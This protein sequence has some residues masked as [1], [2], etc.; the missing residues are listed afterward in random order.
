MRQKK[1]IF[2]I[3]L[4]CLLMLMVLAGLYLI[5]DS[6][7]VPESAKQYTDLQ[8]RVDL[9]VKTEDIR[10]WQDAVGMYYFFLPSTGDLSSIAFVNIADED[11]LTIN[12]ASSKKGYL[13]EAFGEEPL[14]LE[15]V[16]DMQLTLEGGQALE[17][18]QVQF[19]KS[20]NLATMFID[21]ESG[22]LD[23]IHSSKEIEEKA[24]VILVDA[25]GEINYNNDIQYIRTRGNS[26]FHYYDKKAYQ[27]KLYNNASLLDMTKSEKWILLANAV[28][29]SLIRNALIYDFADEYTNIPSIEGRFIDLYVN[30]T[31][32]GN[33]YL[34]EKIEVDD[35]RLNIT[36]LEAYNIAENGAVKVNGATSFQTEDGK[37]RACSGIKNPKDITGG[38][39]LER[40]PEAEYA[41]VLSG[42][43]TN[44]GH[45]FEIVSPKYATIEQA[46]YIC[47]LFNE[48]EVAI[49]ADDGINPHTGKHYT[50]YIDLDSWIEKYLIDEL[51]HN[52]DAVV[53]SLFFYKDS[54]H[55]DTHIFAGPVWDYDRAVGSYG[56][57]AYEL[58]DPLNLGN[59]GIYVPELIQK[60]PE[61]KGILVKKFQDIFEVY[62]ENDLNK[63][64]YEYEQLLEA[65]HKSNSIRWPQ[66]YGYYA[67][68]EA[69][70]EY[71]KNFMQTKKNTL[72]EIWLEDTIYHTVTFLGY[73]NSSFK[74]Y[75]VRHG[76]CLDDYVPEPICK[77]AFFAGWENQETGKSFDSRIPVLEDSVYASTW[78]E[79]NILLLNGLDI[80]DMDLSEVNADDIAH[81]AELVREQQK[82][83]EQ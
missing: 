4:I 23:A 68:L 33:Y 77:A 27:L 54:D 67:G 14:L 47:N 21:T 43:C 74:S 35:Q 1:R 26:T 25:E 79:L 39:L 59:Y 7:E 3:S 31:Y 22:G 28:D 15:H 60:Y 24:S 65:S 36:D 8:I 76:S 51:F 42:F 64:L 11:E 2:N 9:G 20:A 58:N 57:D 49:A 82:Q 45:Y 16:Y 61:V 72:Q 83:I 37:I 40:I 18:A 81:L 48:F 30:G 44:D 69:N 19:V 62:I 56:V 50:E 5:T 41:S 70:V 73:D 46:E 38:Y 29:D 52:P 78:I 75:K 34:C 17:P 13:F 12:D 6:V 80:A 63:D 66:N 10:I 53:A 32:Q 71:I 55:V